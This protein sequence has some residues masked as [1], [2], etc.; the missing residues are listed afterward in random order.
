MSPARN[1]TFWIF[2]AVMNPRSAR[3]VVGKDGQESLRLN[4]LVGN[5]GWSPTYTV[6]AG[7][8]HKEM[9][10]ECSAL[11]NQLTGEDWTAVKLTLST[12]SPALAASSPGLAPLPI[13]LVPAT[14]TAKLSEKEVLEQ[15]QSI[16]GRRSGWA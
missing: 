15:A 2:F 13:T 14:Q 7:K 16:K 4:Y 1:T 8:D 6:R 5:C 9:A 10:L 3:R 11:I 12:A